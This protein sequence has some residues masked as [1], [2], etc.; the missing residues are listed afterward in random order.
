MVESVIVESG[1]TLLPT[2]GPAEPPWPARAEE[3]WSALPPRQFIER[4]PPDASRMQ[5]S[6]PLRRPDSQDYYTPIHRMAPLLLLGEREGPEDAWG[7]LLLERKQWVSTH[8]VSLARLEGSAGHRHRQH[9]WHL[10]GRREA[11]VGPTG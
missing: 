7:E 2:R 10:P 3:A 11:R 6:Q 8:H 4:Q 9:Q 5:H 1:H